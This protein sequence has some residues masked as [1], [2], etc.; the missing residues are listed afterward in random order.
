MSKETWPKK[1]L[2]YIKQKAGARYTPELN[3]ELPISKIF[4][5]ISRNEQ[6]Y[7]DTRT[8]YGE[9]LR[10][11]RYASN[12]YENLDLQNDYNFIAKEIKSL[13]KII[14][15][16]KIYNTEKIPWI[17]IQKKA[18]LLKDKIWELLRKLEQEKEQ[19]KDVKLPEKSNGGYQSS[20]SER[21]GY[22]IH[23]IRKTQDLVRYFEELSSNTKSRLSN[24]PF[25]L[26]TG[27][28]G[29]GKTH[30][31][32]DLVEQRFE[33]GK[34][35]NFLL[36][37]E[38]FVDKDNF[39]GEAIGQLNLGKK[40]RTADDFLK[41]IDLLGE[42]TKCRSLLII[43]ALNENITQSP[44]YWKKNLIEIIKKVKKHPNVGL[45]ISLRNGYEKNVLS[46]EVQTRLIKLEHHGFT[47]EIIWNA[48]NSFFKH[49]NITFP[50]V[51]LLHPEFY[52]PL[53][54]KFF[55]E[56]NKNSKPSLK[57]GNAL[58]DVFEDFVIEIGLEVL[59]ELDPKA[60]K[61]KNG[62]NVLWDNIIKDTALWMIF[63]G[64]T[65]IPF[66]D[67][68][69]I[70]SKYFPTKEERIIALM[71]R[72][73]LLNKIEWGTE[74][75]YA[76]SYNKFSDHIIV[77]TLLTSVPSS[78]RR[79]EF[80]KNGKIWQAIQN[81]KYDHGILEA[82][83]IQVPEFFKKEPK[84]ELFELAP[85]VL[86]DGNFDYPFRESII[87]RD[88]ETIDDKVIKIIEKNIK[89]KEDFFLE[90]L[91][92]LSAFPDSPLNA[93]LLNSLLR[94]F[95][96]PERDSWWSTF[97]HYQHGEHGA[98]DRLLQWAWSNQERKHIADESIFL[99][100]I[101]LAWFL[102][103]PNRF[104]RDKATKGLVCLLQ[105]RIN[106][107]PQLLTEFRDVNDI[108]IKERLFVISY[109]CVLRNRNDRESLK[110]LAEWVYGNIFKDNEPPVHILLRDYARGIIEVAKNR[111]LRIKSDNID[112]PYKSAWPSTIPDGEQLKKRYYPEDYF[113]DKTK[114]R[115]F[116]DIWS[117]VMYSYGTL[118]DFGNYVIDSHL[119]PWSGRNRSC[120][121]PRRKDIFNEFKKQLSKKQKEVLEKA[122]N[123]FFGVDLSR[124]YEYIKVDTEKSEK[125][126]NDK[127]EEQKELFKKFEAIL[128][129]SQ[130]KIFIEE[131]KPFFDERGT[132]NDP[133]DLFDTKIAQRWV[134]NRVIKLGYNPKIHEE[135]DSMVNRYDNSGRSDHKAERIG[136]KYQWIAYHEF[137]AI[138]SDH[139]E[140][141]GDSWSSQRKEKYKGTWKP[142]IRDID[143]S[144]IL[145]NDAHIKKIVKL[146]NWKS[147]VG[148][149]DGWEKQKA[150]DVWISSSNDLPNPKRIIH[151]KDDSK[152]DWLILDGFVDWE[153]KAP[154]EYKKYDVPARQLWYMLKSYIIKRQDAEEFFR[155]AKR[156]N[157]R[158]RW[159]P[160]SHDIYEIFFGEYPN[161][162]AYNDLRGNYNTWTKIGRGKGDLPV[163]VVVTDDSYLNE[164]TRDCS[165][166]GAVSV[167]LPSK[168]L[169]NKMKL[170][171]EQTDGI[172]Y[173]KNKEVVALPTS[174]FEENFPSVLLIDKKALLEF[175]RKNGYVIFWTLLGEKQLIGGN[176]AESRKTGRLDI[177]GIYTI[178]DKGNIIGKMSC[179]IEK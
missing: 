134:F 71:E 133:L 52:N 50:E 123:P 103:T 159:M 98:V 136:K 77:R 172:F 106:L 17:K 143:S 138:V 61:R 69:N 150:D 111:G 174:I 126:D 64:K 163:S 86:K 35:N 21:L 20:P 152:K 31:L 34:N 102:T 148:H 155:W 26:L 22:D 162:K 1:H 177:S 2:A 28:A 9:L 74:T 16:I 140:F 161:S 38:S 80:K 113:K 116:L 49:Y 5:G 10:E 135:F 87:W 84:K 110:I 72:R 130:R 109:S 131:I 132:I 145:Q 114:E 158:G 65:R 36:F 33:E 56:K 100:S 42:K 93:R 45:I 83:C 176:H 53:F 89:G 117:S 6:F 62:K 55:C 39:W 120:P 4:D 149:Y 144:F 124:L 13:A 95:T 179:E 137:L 118:G 85:Y 153:E 90:P 27:S 18:S 7:I 25:L 97:L 108:Y 14:D 141:R 154:P 129:K 41:K 78:Q 112:P 99:T 75:S 170:K 96:M 54:L 15:T 43:D 58:K 122:T 68:K 127:K 46:R 48:I 24:A 30:L 171:H 94:E 3:V 165:S 29:N 175:L 44:N 146:R 121:E 178:N 128:T 142:Y 12:S 19:L 168:W 101:T 169:V 59:K 160:E 23:H 164:F 63:N 70:I 73:V 119:H 60:V 76:F 166:D 11:F 47:Q 66:L 173:G 82:M 125:Q 51:P 91:L 167:K 107:L 37:G 79:S 81:F 115:G 157:F 57:G 151:I 32:C 156:K 88:P 40:I 67:L 105:D 92:S 147:G 8:K 104:I 139:F